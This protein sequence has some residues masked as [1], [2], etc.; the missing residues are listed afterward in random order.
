MIND[1]VTNELFTDEFIMTELKLDI[2]TFNKRQQFSI[3][4]SVII[5]KYLHKKVPSLFGEQQ[6]I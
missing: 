4:E 3:Q 2:V 6:N 5:K 1:Y